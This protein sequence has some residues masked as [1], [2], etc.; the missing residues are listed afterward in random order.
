MRNVIL[1]LTPL[2]AILPCGTVRAQDKPWDLV[3]QV[4]SIEDA[5]DL[6]IKLANVRLT[7][8]EFSRTG[9]T[10]DQG[11]F[12]I[13]MP[14]VAKP[15]QEVSFSHDQ[16][17][18]EIFHPFRGLQ[19]LPAPSNPPP[20]IEVRMLPKGSK[21]WKSDKFIDAHTEYE[22]SRSAQRLAGEAGGRFDFE[23]SLR[24]L[25]SY[26]G[27]GEQET[28]KQLTAYI[29]KYR[30]DATDRHRQA[31]AEFLARNYPLAGDLY[32]KSAEGL[33]R[34]GV[35]Q[36]RLAAYEREAA[37]DAFYNALDFARASS[38]YQ[39]A[40]KRLA[41]Y[42]STRMALELDDYPESGPDRR[43][44]I[45][46]VANAKA[47]L[48]IRVAGPQLTDHLNEAVRTYRNLLDETPRLTG[49][50]DWAGTQNNLGTAL[51]HLASRSAGPR[52]ATLLDEAIAAYRSALTV[53]TR[54]QLPQHWARTQDNL[55]TALSDL[56]S[57]SAGPRAATLLDEA[58]AAYR[59]ALTV[60]TREQLPQDWA[61]TQDNLGTALRHFASRSAGPRAATLLDEAIAAYRSALAVR[62][63]EQLPQDWARTQNNLGTA[64]SDLASRSAGPRA[65][66]LLDE[67]VAAYRSALTVFTRKQLP[68]HWARTQNNLRLTLQTYFAANQF[69]A[70]L[71]QLDRLRQ[72]KAFA[73]DPRFVFLVDVLRVTCYEALA[74][75][76]RVNEA[77]DAL[78][79]HVERQAETFRI[80][81]SFSRLR[82]VVEQSKLEAI[83]A[84][85]GFLLAFLDAVSK[86]NRQGVLEGLRRLRK[87]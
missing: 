3:G 65:A 36:I 72:E 79:V 75:E 7:V 21:R 29:K 8:R 66:T 82:G 41:A 1:L 19:R 38:T 11:Q 22:R 56:A 77:L 45:F 27:L 67:A 50:Q 52:A 39:D 31:N 76:A 69:R 28:Q 23:A 78:I 30:T 62:T 43:R 55:G 44:L 85:R 48:G 70:G 14:A 64:L 53:F 5:E 17:Q 58:I 10:D 2:L 68:Q 80:P 84:N 9:L 63:R 46:K 35:E 32:L 71:K 60:F 59:S 73:D 4:V 26:T 42:R 13:Q 61:G 16:D 18:Y 20:I 51:S 54:E 83:V 40:G 15:G 87:K 12:V 49:P 81:W 25:A 6:P 86:E 47:E 34:A 37:G 33:E 57:R 74:E 24:E